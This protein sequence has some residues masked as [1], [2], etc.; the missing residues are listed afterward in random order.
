MTFRYTWL[1]S[2]NSTPNLL[3]HGLKVHRHTDLV[4]PPVN[5]WVHSV[6]ASKYFSKYHWLQPPSSHNH[7][8]HVDVL[9]SSIAA[10]TYISESAQSW[11]A[12]LFLSSLTHNLHPRE[13]ANLLDNMLHTH[14]LV[15]LIGI[16]RRFSECIWAP[17]EA[18]LTV[19]IH[20]YQ[21]SYK[22]HI[23]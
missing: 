2:P 6:P 15:H 8:L 19:C 1:W 23:I 16:P 4:L 5:L 21:L 22:I 12:S 18:G 17:S 3:N 14:I 13:S 20:I 11:P 9:S 10:A 7:S